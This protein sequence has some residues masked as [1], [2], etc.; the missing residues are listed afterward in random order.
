VIAAEAGMSTRDERHE[1]YSIPNADILFE[2]VWAEESDDASCPACGR[3]LAAG[4]ARCVS[5]GESIA[6][7]IG[8]CSSCVSPHCVG[9]PQ[10]R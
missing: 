1:R 3:A 4:A 10:G 2:D 9:S 7:C 5:C 6:I 8:S